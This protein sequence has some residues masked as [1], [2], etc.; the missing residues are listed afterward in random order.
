MTAK[1]AR[2]KAEK[3]FRR[4]FRN[5]IDE[6]GQLLGP[7]DG[8][9]LL[10]GLSRP[11]DPETPEAPTGLELLALGGGR[12]RA[13][14]IGSRRANSINFYKQVVGVDADMVKIANVPGETIDMDGLPAGSQVK[15]SA[16]GVNDAGE[17]PACDPVMISVT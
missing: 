12:V 13:T 5:T 2:D 17:G 1:T 11:I 10:F 16:T 14:I 9:W 15:V 7:D 3:I 4:R 8:R 6:L